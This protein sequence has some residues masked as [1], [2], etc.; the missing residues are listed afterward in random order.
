M[1]VGFLLVVPFVVAAGSPP[2][3]AAAGWLVLAGVGNTLGLLFEYA[4]LRIGKV[5]IVASIASTEGAVAAV[6]SAVAGEPMPAAA[7]TALAVIAAGV[8]LA[9]LERSDAAGDE[10]TGRAVLLAIGAAFSFGVGLYAAGHVS[11]DVATAW[12]VLPARVIGVVVLAIPLSITGRLR[13]TRRSVPLVVA[14]GICEV[15]G[16]VSFAIGARDAI[17]V[18]SVMG[19]QFAAF[20][21]V[22][23]FLLFGERLR[24]MQL[25]G[26]A[27]IVVGVALLTVARTG[28]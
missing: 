17:G 28:A 11:G 15:V 12:V 6:I 20:A 7:A 26:V 25:A 22:G 16:F 27:T 2:T 10:Q 21:A 4:G 14:A 23:A 3:G 13:I 18:A 24:K 1:L 19:S 5:G 9:T 8:V